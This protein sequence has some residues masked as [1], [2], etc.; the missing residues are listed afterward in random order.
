MDP[1]VVAA[2][3]AA[4]GAVLTGAA[5]FGATALAI[6][7]GRRN[8]QRSLDAERERQLWDRR[9]SAYVDTL[10]HARRQEE[11]WENE[12]RS[13]GAA[14]GAER[15]RLAALQGPTSFEIEARLVAYGSTPFRLAFA[16][17]SNRHTRLGQVYGQWRQQFSG[18]PAPFMRRPRELNS[19]FQAFKAATLDLANVGN[20][21]LQA[22]PSNRPRRGRVAPERW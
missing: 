21:E 20:G 10:A 16:E 2:S 6:R 15:D 22:A 18:P 17:W 9:A 4:G 13:I 1:L 14:E 5:G 7:S 8:L 19:A 3:I 11:V 12:M